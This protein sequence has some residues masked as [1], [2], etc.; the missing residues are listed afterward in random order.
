MPKFSTNILLG[1]FVCLNAQNETKKIKIK[2]QLISISYN[3]NASFLGQLL[4]R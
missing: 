3:L 2:N 4:L 1:C